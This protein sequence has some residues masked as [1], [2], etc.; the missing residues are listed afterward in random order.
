[1][2]NRLPFFV[3][4]ISA[5]HLGKIERAHELIDLAAEAGAS[6][7]K[8]QTY[9]ASTMTLDIPKFSVDADHLLWGGR[10]LYDL[11]LEAHTPWEWHKELFS[12]CLE[13]NLTPFSSPFDE[14]AVDFLESIDCPIYKIASLETGDTTLI[15]KI[16]GTGKPII[17]STGAT[18]LSEIEEMLEII[19]DN[20]SSDITLLVCTSSYPS[21]P[22]DAHLGRLKFLRDKFGVRVGL[23]DHTLGIGVSIAAIALGA[24]VIEK[25]FTKSRSE[26]GP[27]S[28]FSMEPKE[29]KDLV[30][31]GNDA[32]QAIGSEEWI[33]ISIE[34]SSRQL[35]RSLFVTENV[36][37][38]EVATRKNIRSIRPAGGLAPKYLDKL[39]GKRFIQD[40]EIGDPVTLKMF[41]EEI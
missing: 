23:S 12:H 36:K 31:H 3:A 4:E 41:T 1:M 14:S 16:A 13:K 29:F 25:H 37:A 19:K 11:Y 24:I 7:V 21:R 18:T 32:Y 40:A 6:A 28:E 8:F 10:K 20:S 34:D 38:G 2:F 26:S 22:G 17:A 39:L 27:D 5:N 35:R 15:K 30:S 9:K 33:E